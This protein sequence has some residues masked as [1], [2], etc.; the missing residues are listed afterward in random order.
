MTAS[1]SEARAIVGAEIQMITYR[2]FIPIL[3][4]PDALPP[5]RGYNF[6]VDRGSPSLSQP[7]LSESDTHCCRRL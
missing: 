5:Y 2:D 4:G 1:I 6:R 3:L 7:Q